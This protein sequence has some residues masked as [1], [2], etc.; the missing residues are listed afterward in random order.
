MSKAFWDLVEKNMACTD[1][2]YIKT[3]LE[4]N[5][6]DSA[7]TVQTITKEDIGYFETY[8]QSKLINIIDKVNSDKNDTEKYL[9]PFK[10][11]PSTFKIIRGHL[12]LIKKIVE[13]VKSK[14]KDTTD[15]SFFVPPPEPSIF[16]KKKCE[17]RKT[18]K[19][20]GNGTSK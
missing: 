14:I 19:C 7:P 6:Y 1:P 3:V 12:V 13:F 10:D 9:T 2:P 4:L 5:G 18:Q 11:E 17:F 20:R 16:Q 8:I 15:Y